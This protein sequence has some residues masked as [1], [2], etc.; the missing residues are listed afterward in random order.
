MRCVCKIGLALE[1][2]S[3]EVQ[4]GQCSLFGDVGVVDQY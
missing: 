3:I 1:V 4:L 2:K